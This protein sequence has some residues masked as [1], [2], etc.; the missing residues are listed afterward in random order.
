M[1][2]KFMHDVQQEAIDLAKTMKPLIEQHFDSAAPGMHNMTD[3]EHRVWF[4]GMTASDPNWPL[5]LAYVEGGNREVGRYLRTV[6]KDG[7]QNG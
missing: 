5:H 3:L 1:N 6:A 7:M 2:R 4:E